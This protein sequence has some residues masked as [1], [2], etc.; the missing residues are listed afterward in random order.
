RDMH[1]SVVGAG[2]DRVALGAGWRERED[3]AV[4]L[5]PVLIEHERAATGPARRRIGEGE[6]GRDSFP[7]AAFVGRAPDVLRAAVEIIGW[8][9][10][11]D[12]GVGPVPALG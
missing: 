6:V 5:G 11:K 4:N 7:R 2:P 12:D 10:R 8:E 9:L 3:R 1:E